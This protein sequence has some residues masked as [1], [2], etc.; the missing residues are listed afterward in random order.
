MVQ[1]RRM[2][3]DMVGIDLDNSLSSIRRQAINWNLCLFFVNEGHITMKV[4]WD[5]NYFT[6]ENIYIW[7]HCLHNIGHFIQNSVC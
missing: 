1:W 6:Q 5:V 2:A 7:N 3:S 4:C